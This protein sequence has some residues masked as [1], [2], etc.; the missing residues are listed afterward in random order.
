M[1]FSFIS[2]NDEWENHTSDELADNG[3][4]TYNYSWDTNFHVGEWWD[5]FV[6]SSYP[7]YYSNYSIWNNYIYL[8]NTPPTAENFSV[9][10]AVEG[11]GRPFTYEV[12]ISDVQMDNVTV[13]LFITT[14]NKVTWEYKNENAKNY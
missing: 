14:N 1:N 13:R 7:Y 3:D 10:P 2:P 4:G 5:V 6:D 8:N 11:W 9:S 12:N